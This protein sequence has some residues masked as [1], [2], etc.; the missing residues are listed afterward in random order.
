[1]L[2]RPVVLVPLIGFLILALGFA[3]YLDRMVIARRSAQVLSSGLVDRPAPPLAL[4]PLDGAGRPGLAEGLPTGQVA[5][6]NFFASWCV[7][8]RA[9][10]PMLM[11]L[12]KAGVTIYG[13]AYRDKPDEARAFLAARGVP[14]ARIG[15]DADG[16]AAAGWGVEE[17]GVPETFVIDREGRVRYRQVGPIMEFQWNG[18]IGPLVRKLATAT[19]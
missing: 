2:R 12:A 13:V 9:E 10:H 5:L 3:I 1:M 4:P 7:P 19:P 8:C 17:D 16:R 6:V 14:Y 11:R 18:T 15:T